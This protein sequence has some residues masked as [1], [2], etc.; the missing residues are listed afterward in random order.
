MFQL[1]VENTKE[2]FLS[3]D[4]NYD[5]GQIEDANMMAMVSGTHSHTR[6]ECASLNGCSGVCHQIVISM[7]NANSRTK[8]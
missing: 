7:Y 1:K 2:K 4:S 6:H 3:C 5:G 8:Q